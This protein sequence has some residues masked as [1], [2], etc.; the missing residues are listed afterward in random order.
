MLLFGNFLWGLE[1][2]NYLFWWWWCYYNNNFH[3][4]LNFANLSSWNWRK[5]NLPNITRSTV[6]W[7]Y[8]ETMEFVLIIFRIRNHGIRIDHFQNIVTNVSVMCHDAWREG[9]QANRRCL[10]I[11]QYVMVKCQHH[12]SLPNFANYRPWYSHVS[13][14]MEQLPQDTRHWTNVDLMLGHRLRRWPNIKTT[15]DQCFLFAESAQ[16]H[17]QGGVSIE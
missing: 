7:K 12:D 11:S 14:T 9:C 10:G 8:W 13:L 17:R 4:I 6:N 15:L 2:A 5:L 3:E 16:R 1:F